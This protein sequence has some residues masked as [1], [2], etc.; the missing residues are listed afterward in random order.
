MFLTE[1]P[2]PLLT[3]KFGSSFM[4]TQSNPD[5]AVR[6]R[7][8]RK[9][10][11]ALPTVNRAVIRSVLELF[12][13]VL[14]HRRKNKLTVSEF[15]AD[16]GP[17]LLGI[18]RST[19]PS[20][21]TTAADVLKT[22]ITQ[23]QFM[24]GTA[25]EPA[26]Y[27]SLPLYTKKSQR[28]L[29]TSN[30]RARGLIQRKRTHTPTNSTIV[31]SP[32]P[33]SATLAPNSA[34]TNSL[35]GSG[36]T[37][38]NSSNSLPDIASGA[39]G[40]ALHLPPSSITPPLPSVDESEELVSLT[41][42]IMLKFLDQSV[43]SV[44]FEPQVRISFNYEAKIPNH[45]KRNYTLDKLTE[46]HRGSSASES[47]HGAWRP[48]LDED[49]PHNPMTSSGGNNSR[50]RRDT[51]ASANAKEDEENAT[52]NTSSGNT[53]TRRNTSSGVRDDS[54]GTFERTRR[55]SQD[56]GEQNSTGA[57]SGPSVDDSSGSTSSHRRS[58]RR[59]VNEDYTARSLGTQEDSRHLNRTVSEELSTS[60]EWIAQTRRRRSSDNLDGLDFDSDSSDSE[61]A[62]PGHDSSST[63]TASSQPQKRRKKPSER[64]SASSKAGSIKRGHKDKETSHREKRRRAAHSSIEIASSEDLSAEL[65]PMT[66]A[67]LAHPATA[68]TAAAPLASPTSPHSAAATSSSALA[69]TSATTTGSTTTNATSTAPTKTKAPRPKSKPPQVVM[70]SKTI[71]EMAP[72]PPSEM[73]PPLAMP[74]NTTGKNKTPVAPPSV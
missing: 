5:L 41:D 2:E 10:L 62:V 34:L 38:H 63:T 30:S 65:L 29:L 64:R 27:D 14:H 47:R 55:K 9:L 31:T 15:C 52:P 16:M 28:V 57:D 7:N 66:T 70:D 43:R 21:A 17:I 4:K 26:E 6:Y 8:M 33:H 49:H 1:L 60:D 68:T 22:L 69:G 42:G 50:H 48:S 20:D 25:E 56:A 13:L 12:R 73:P 24:M 11:N 3:R 59:S 58:R 54:T 39:S 51:T 45:L 19:N 72:S 53:R 71:M 74:S 40:L 44:L 37:I 67:A 23:F 32:A 35:S 36:S 18:D 46:S 61:G